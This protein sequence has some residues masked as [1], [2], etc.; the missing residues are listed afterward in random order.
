MV[1]INIKAWATLLFSLF[2]LTLETASVMKNVSVEFFS[3]VCILDRTSFLKWGKSIS[4][5]SQNHSLIFEVIASLIFWHLTKVIF[6]KTVFLGP[7]VI[8]NLC[9]KKTLNVKELSIVIC[10]RFWIQSK[11]IANFEIINMVHCWNTHHRI[12]FNLSSL[13][14]GLM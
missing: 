14:K 13:S 4:Q 5:I 12:Y 2:Q 1:L 10:K 3:D 8:E 9:I 11:S 7:L 6:I